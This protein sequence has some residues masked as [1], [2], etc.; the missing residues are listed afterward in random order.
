MVELREETRVQWSLTERLV[1]SRQEKNGGVKGRDESAVEL[2]E[3]LVRSRQEKNG[4][5]TGR[6]GSAVE[7]DRET[8]ETGEEQTGE[9]WWS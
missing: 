1:R 8:G 5:V 2:T 6:D 7:L 3:R 4:G 9:E